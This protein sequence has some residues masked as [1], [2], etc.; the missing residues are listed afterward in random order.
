MLNLTPNMLLLGQFLNVVCAFD[1][2]N[3][4]VLE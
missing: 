4:N 3:I 1:D 2:C